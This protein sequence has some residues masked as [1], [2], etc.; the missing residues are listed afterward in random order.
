MA[1]FD[2]SGPLVMSLPGGDANFRSVVSEAPAGEFD[3]SS[4]IAMG[5]AGGWFTSGDPERVGEEFDDSS[6]MAIGIVSSVGRMLGSGEMSGRTGWVRALADMSPSPMTQTANP[7]TK[8]QITHALIFSAL[9]V[10]DIT[11]IKD[12]NTKIRSQ[13][14]G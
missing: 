2:E 1:K 6:G 5:G 4:G 12:Q 14:K 9:N 13:F 10:E 7:A 3:D 11:A 8:I